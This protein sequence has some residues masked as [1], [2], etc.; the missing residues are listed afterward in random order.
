MATPKG[1]QDQS[2]YIRHG[3]LKKQLDAAT[4]TWMTASEELEML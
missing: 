3:E 4:E 1:S 2:L